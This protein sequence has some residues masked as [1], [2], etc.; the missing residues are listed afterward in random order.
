MKALFTGLL[1]CISYYGF[2]ADYNILTFGA[3]A[4]GKTIN[5]KAIQM[6]IDK[7]S[8]QHGGRVII[9][10][11]IFM[12]GTIILKNDVTLYLEDGAELKGSPDS[13]DYPDQK[14]SE[15]KKATWALVVAQNVKH[16]AIAGH[17]TINGNGAVAAF[18]LGDDT[19]PG[20]KGVRPNIIT[21]VNCKDIEILNVHLL[22]S[23]HWMETYVRCEYLHIKGVQVYNHANLNNDGINIDSRNVLIEDCNIDSDDDG[24]CLKSDDPN[25][26]CENVT[27]RNCVVASNCNAVKFGTGSRS[28]FRNINISNI[29][30]HKASEDN[31]RHWQS[32][33]KF[34]DQPITTIA[35]LSIENVDGGFTDNVTIDNVFM[36][37][38]QTP[39]FIK[40]GKRGALKSKDPAS[41]NP[42]HV[43]NIT[44]SNVTAVSHSKITSSITGFPGYD[45]ENVV[46]SN[47]NISTMGDGT[48]DEADAPLPEKETAYPESRM[49]GATLPSSG[50]Y[51]RHVKG[52]SLQNITLQTR[53]M[54]ARPAIIM[55]DVKNAQISLLNTEQTEITNAAIKLINCE[56][57]IWLNPK[58]TNAPFP[59][60]TVDG[61]KTR[62]ISIVGMKDEKDKIKSSD[63]VAKGAVSI[64]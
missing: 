32:H 46:L 64:N 19:A 9:P 12:S 8:E 20:Y 63:I 41:F 39:I 45:V 58:V 14:T 50:L 4:D 28:G 5:T 27:I 37:D 38:I 7:C 55:D 40:L 13:K 51:I 6:S 42:G 54:D 21:M 23:A 34:I 59:V 43:R 18:Q 62:A 2:S 33:I 47:I 52:I 36:E 22:N 35:G 3:K 53:N 61:E 60:L 30:I 17:G 11:G 56:S 44:I 29:T 16:I 31:F 15:G 24:I 25:I 49:F 48:A 26:P 1:L 10:A 57:V